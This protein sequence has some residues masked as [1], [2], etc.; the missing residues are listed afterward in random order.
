MSKDSTKLTHKPLIRFDWLRMTLALFFLAYVFIVAKSLM[1]LPDEP[2]RIKFLEVL[3]VTAG[4]V[5]A[6]HALITQYRIY[7][8]GVLAFLAWPARVQLNERIEFLQTMIQPHQVEVYLRWGLILGGLLVLLPKA[9]RLF[10]RSLKSV[11]TKKSRL[12]K[13]GVPF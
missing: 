3:C 8:L 5:L 2:P 12:F 13:A 7:I 1:P 9:F 4:L 10:H 11:T 6:Y